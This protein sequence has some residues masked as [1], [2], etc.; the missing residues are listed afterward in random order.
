MRPAKIFVRALALS[1]LVLWSCMSTGRWEQLPSAEQD[2][3]QR[4]REAMRVNLCGQ[5]NDSF[6]LANCYR[7]SMSQYADSPDERGRRE[8]LLAHGCPPSMV[9]PGRYA[10][11][12]G[13][14]HF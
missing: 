1:L 12:G 3:F 9:T 4:C 5:S 6:Y 8:W 2:S 13:A 7:S 11:S 14:R 10:S